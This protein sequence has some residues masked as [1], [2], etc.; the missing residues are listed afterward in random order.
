MYFIH[1]YVTVYMFH[2][3]KYEFLHSLVHLH[4]IKM[5]PYLSNEKWGIWK[6]KDP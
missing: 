2:V 1:V 3:Y 6:I 4:N 5:Y